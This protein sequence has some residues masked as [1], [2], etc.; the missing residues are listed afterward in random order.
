MGLRPATIS[1][2]SRT[3]RLKSKGRKRHKAAHPREAKRTY[4]IR[5]RCLLCNSCTLTTPITA[6]IAPSRMYCSQNLQWTLVQV[7][8]H[9]LIPPWP[10]RDKLNHIK[11]LYQ[12]DQNKKMPNI[13]NRILLQYKISAKIIVV[14]CL[15]KEISLAPTSP[16]EQALGSLKGNTAVTPQPSPKDGT[17]M[18]QHAFCCCKRMVGSE[19][20]MATE[21]STKIRWIEDNSQRISLTSLLAF[22]IGGKT[23][24]QT[25]RGWEDSLSL[26]KTSKIWLEINR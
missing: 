3:T 2:K 11:F 19:T 1:S 23:T 21:C 13:P 10:K 5:T 25:T 14:I 15:C 26:S 6:F 20:N 22:V 9:T 17:N 4:H 7:A 12:W 24:L 16:T 18:S 8:R